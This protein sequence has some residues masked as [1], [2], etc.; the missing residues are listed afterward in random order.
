M[1]PGLEIPDREI[2]GV[3]GP[4][5]FVRLVVQTSACSSPVYSFYETPKYS[6]STVELF[7]DMLTTVAITV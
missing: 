7:L 3:P 5:M 2:K 6:M 4:N 1:V